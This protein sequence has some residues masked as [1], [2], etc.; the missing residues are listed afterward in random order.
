MPKLPLPLVRPMC[1]RCGRPADAV[2]DNAWHPGI[3]DDDLP[4]LR[5]EHDG[6]KPCA[7]SRAERERVINE[8]HTLNRGV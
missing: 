4:L 6:R 3:T 5:I 2:V 1:P 8:F 7:I